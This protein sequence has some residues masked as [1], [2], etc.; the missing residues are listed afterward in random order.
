MTETT[1]QTLPVDAYL[2][3]SFADTPD[4]EPTEHTLFMSAAL[5]RRIAGLSQAYG[6]LTQM[7]IDPHI[8]SLLILEAI[9][10]R[11]KKGE[12][13]NPNLTLDDFPM[14]EKTAREILEWV[15]KHNSNFFIDAVSKAKNSITLENGPLKRLMDSLAGLAPSQNVKSSVG[16]SD[17]STPKSTT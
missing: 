8:Q 11:T 12:K 9:R 2:K 1:E 5:T 16:D 4:G 7:Y 17:V 3:V 6:D 14:D 13:E 10:P 15:L